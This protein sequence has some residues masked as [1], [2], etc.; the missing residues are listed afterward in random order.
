MTGPG[1]TAEASLY[2]SRRSYVAH[3]TAAPSDEIISAGLFGPPQISVSWAGPPYP[4]GVGFPGTLNISG[5]NFAA[6]NF[7]N[8]EITNCNSDSTPFFPDPVPTS[9]F[10][11]FCYYHLGIRFCEAQPGGNFSYT[12]N[13]CVCGGSTTVTATDFLGNTASA[14]A[15]IPC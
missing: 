6:S 1:F 12:T 4:E 10:H 2:L 3:R 7:V 11:V 15:N 14:T 8:L 13:K 5:Q 9:A